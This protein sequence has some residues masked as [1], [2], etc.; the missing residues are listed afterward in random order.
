MD[1]KDIRDS[2]S[3][4]EG[5]GNEDINEFENELGDDEDSSKPKKNAESRINELVAEVKETKAEL[6]KLRA[7]K[8]P[9]PTPPVT[10]KVDENP[11]AQKAVEYLKGL[12]FQQS[13]DVEEKVKAI[14]DRIALDNE[15]SRLSSGYDGADG[16]PKYDRAKVEAYMRDHAV[17]DPEIAYK[18]LNEPELLD[19]NLKKSN[20]GDKKKPYVERPGS[21]SSNRG[22]NTITREKLA[23]VSA[24]PTPVNR[25]WYERNRD[26][27]LQLMAEG[28]I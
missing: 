15:H 14:E 8:V 4:T 9:T 5:E 21:G 24:N 6:E 19:W 12:G 28:N 10:K 23:E 16:K 11:Q 20:S 2:E 18:S 27:I 26:K 3:S 17:Y 22:D 13:G 7:E 1:D 25:A